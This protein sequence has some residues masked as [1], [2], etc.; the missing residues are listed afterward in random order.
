MT[1]IG[2]MAQHSRFCM[3]G[4]VD[5]CIMY[6]V[7]VSGCMCMCLVVFACVCFCICVWLH[8]YV[9]V[10]ASVS[11]SCCICIFLCLVVSLSDVA[12]WYQSISGEILTCFK[13]EHFSSS[14][15]TEHFKGYLS[16]SK[17]N[18]LTR[19]SS[20]YRYFEYQMT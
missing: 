2:Y 19:F 1:D 7:S 14:K 6:Q 20:Y 8:V 9:F 10:S 11:V 3:C 16:H 17:Y 15:M 13:K 18:P 5:K 4:S 12:L